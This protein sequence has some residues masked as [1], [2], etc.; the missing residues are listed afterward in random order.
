MCFNFRCVTN[1]RFT[2]RLQKKNCHFKV[3]LLLTHDTKLYFKGGK[4]HWLVCT[5]V[6]QENVV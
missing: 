1:H 2:N 6:P 5:P 3:K 4:W